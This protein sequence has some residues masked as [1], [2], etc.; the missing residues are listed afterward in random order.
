MEYEEGLYQGEWRKGERH[1]L[2]RAEYWDEEEYVSQYLG[3][4]EEGRWDGEGVTVLRNGKVYDGV[5]KHNCRS[6]R[7]KITMISGSFVEGDWRR[8]RL[9]GEGTVTIADEDGEKEHGTGKIV[10]DG[11]ENDDW[12]IDCEKTEFYDNFLEK[13]V[14]DVTSMISRGCVGPFVIS[15]QRSH[16]EKESNCGKGQGHDVI[17]VSVAQMKQMLLGLTI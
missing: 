7:G 9:V 5:F 6:G 3:D 4:W 13:V 2:G 1:G 17:D 8:C 11:F 15:K 14:E 12:F 16:F 10:L